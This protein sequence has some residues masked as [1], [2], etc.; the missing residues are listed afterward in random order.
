MYVPVHVLQ[1]Y[2]RS[3]EGEGGAGGGEEMEVSS[4]RWRGNL[5]YLIAIGHALPFLPSP[6]PHS[7]FPL[8]PPRLFLHQNK[9]EPIMQAVPLPPTLLPPPR[10]LLD[11]ALFVLIEQGAS[12][13]SQSQRPY[14]DEGF[15][16]GLKVQNYP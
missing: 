15:K 11:C 13:P 8:F 2:A 12:L 16:R 6:P 9:P 3:R 5:I 14:L 4:E 10:S 1:Y 7:S